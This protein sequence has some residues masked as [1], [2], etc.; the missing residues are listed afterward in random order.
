MYI[1]TPYRLLRQAVLYGIFPAVLLG[2]ALSWAY[3]KRRRA[4]LAKL[5]AGHAAGQASLVLKDVYRFKDVYEV[6]W[7]C[8]IHCC[9]FAGFRVQNAS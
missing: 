2:A 6:R 3:M 1:T 4:P 5:V 9:C 8:G 7:G